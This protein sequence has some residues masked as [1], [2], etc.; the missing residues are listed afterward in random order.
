MFGVTITAGK[1]GAFVG[2]DAVQ[3]G[4]SEHLRRNFCVTLDTAIRHHF[5]PPKWNVTRAA[6][7]NLGM[8]CDPIQF[9]TLLVI[10]SARA[11][12]LSATGK[13]DAHQNK[14][15]DEGGDDTRTRKTSKTIVVHPRLLLKER[16][17]IQ[18]PADMSKRG[19]EQGNTNGN[20]NGVP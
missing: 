5:A 17:V 11:E 10:E 9:F 15:C 3:L 13:C 18:R 14:N 7:L 1:R 16:G 12:H 4:D 8:G 6:F 20:V 19:N 2:D